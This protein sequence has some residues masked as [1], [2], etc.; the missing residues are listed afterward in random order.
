VLNSLGETARTFGRPTDALNHHTAAHTVA[1]DTGDRPQQARA[2]TG[3]GHAHRALGNPALAHEHYHDALA[4]YT[5]LGRP[6]AYQIRA[7]LTN[8]DLTVTRG[9]RG[10]SLP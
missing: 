2:L 6:E 1:A 4:L 3:I 9:H 10:R 7:Y 5:D 8:V